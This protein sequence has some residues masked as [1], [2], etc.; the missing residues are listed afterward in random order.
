M[1]QISDYF[2]NILVDDAADIIAEYLDDPDALRDMI[3]TWIED[4]MSSIFEAMSRA[5]VQNAT[6]KLIEEVH[7]CL[8]LG[9]I[10][11]DCIAIVRHQQS[12]NPWIH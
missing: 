10:T 3:G 1:N 12:L 11:N 7:D 8:D 4:D 9:K 6:W 5:E 2:T